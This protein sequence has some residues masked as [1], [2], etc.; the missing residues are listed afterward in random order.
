MDPIQP[1]DTS[2]DL[3]RQV[4]VIDFNLDLDYIEVNPPLSRLLPSGEFHAAGRKSRLGLA[5]SRPTCRGRT[6]RIKATTETWTG[7]TALLGDSP[8]RV[9]GGCRDRQWP[10]THLV[11]AKAHILQFST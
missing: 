10:E 3:A 6:S 4:S 1:Y 11:S 5:D 9:A 8:L 7:R 2:L